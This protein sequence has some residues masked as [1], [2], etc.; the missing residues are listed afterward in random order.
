MA[1]PSPPVEHILGQPPEVG[2]SDR[3]VA[4]P[5][6]PH[7]LQSSNWPARVPERP[8]G[9]V[10]AMFRLSLG[11]ASH[12]FQK[13]TAGKCHYR[14]WLQLLINFDLQQNREPLPVTVIDV[15]TV[16]CSML[17]GQAPNR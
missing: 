2:K 9:I 13:G 6:C 15:H 10:L 5:I 4:S 3:S 1:P 17:R 14:N 16:I 8:W 12:T 7:T 11:P